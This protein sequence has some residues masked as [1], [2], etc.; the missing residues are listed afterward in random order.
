MT[1]EDSEE[2]AYFTYRHG[3]NPGEYATINTYSGRY[4]M[5]NAPTKTEI[6]VD[7]FSESDPFGS[8]FRLKRKNVS[9]SN[10]LRNIDYLFPNRVAN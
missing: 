6:P 7:E 9:N 10:R 4:L 5:H 1:P 2:W 8:D 3:I